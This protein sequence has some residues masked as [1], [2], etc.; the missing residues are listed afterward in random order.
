MK[1]FLKK[2]S[3]KKLVAKSKLL[4][5]NAKKVLKYREHL[6][7][8]EIYCDILQKISDLERNISSGNEQK[9]RASFGELDKLLKKNGGEIYPIRFLNDNVEVLFVASLL[10]IALRTFFI[11]SFQIPTNSMYPTYYGMMHELSCTPSTTFGNFLS[12]IKFWDTNI[13]VIARNSGRVYIPVVAAKSSSGDK[14]Y[15]SPY[16]VVPARKWFGL[17]S[18]NVRR[19]FIIVNSELHTFDVPFEFSADKVLLDNFFHEEKSFND[20][21]NNRFGMSE[22]I[23][24]T[25]NLATDI[26]VERGKSILCFKILPGDMLFVDKISPHFRQPKVGESVVFTTKSI[27]NFGDFDKYLIKRVVGKGGDRV[28]IQNGQLRNDRS[29]LASNKIVQEINDHH[30]YVAL[31]GLSDGEI[32]S[33]PDGHYFVLGDNSSNSNDS[34]FWGSVPEESVCGYPLM[35]FFPFS[36]RFGRCR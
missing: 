31:G 19:Y 3:Y 21:I 26:S 18:T 2:N 23:P 29:S 13:N 16:K 5:S 7:D 30:G 17:R 35:I 20:V 27:K 32:V 10:A 8:S 14:V 4:L 9:L 6:L 28:E 25:I 34:R 1:I 33:V 12:N 24:D 15:T 36:D 22:N 11:Q